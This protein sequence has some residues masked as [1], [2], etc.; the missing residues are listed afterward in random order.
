MLVLRDSKTQR[1]PESS[2]NYFSVFVSSMPL[3]KKEENSGHSVGTS[4]TNSMIVISRQVSQ[5]FKCSWM[6]KRIYHGM[7]CFTS[8]VKLIMEVESL[9]IGIV[10][11]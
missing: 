9:T 10:F 8:L 2:K 5:T 6:I 3:F 7:P 1:N 4:G 11:V